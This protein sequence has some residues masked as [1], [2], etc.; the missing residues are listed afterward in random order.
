[1]SNFNEIFDRTRKI[2]E[3]WDELDRERERVYGEEGANPKLKDK[4]SPWE[5]LSDRF[6]I[7][8][9][10]IDE[11]AYDFHYK[12]H[13]DLI[14]SIGVGGLYKRSPYMFIQSLK[15]HS[16][17]A[18]KMSD[19]QLKNVLYDICPDLPET[20]EEYEQFKNKQI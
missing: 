8:T 7:G 4:G 15:K 16:I 13:K 9:L 20:R 1:M 5:L 17:K 3:D 19:E 18:S 6:D 11:I 12:G 10:D 14:P 2:N